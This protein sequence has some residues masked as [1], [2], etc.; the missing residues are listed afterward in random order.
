MIIEIIL[1]VESMYS[2]GQ[3]VQNT[4]IINV[5]KQARDPSSR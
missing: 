2:T 5:D 1:T 3:K 4:L